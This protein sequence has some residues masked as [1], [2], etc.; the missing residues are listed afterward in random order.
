[1]ARSSLVVLYVDRCHGRCSRVKHLM[2]SV[3]YTHTL[4]LYIIICILIVATTTRNIVNQGGIL[5]FDWFVVNEDVE[6]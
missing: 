5:Q 4:Y 3:C 1:M 2:P 6:I